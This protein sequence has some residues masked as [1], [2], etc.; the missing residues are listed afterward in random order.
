MSCL[1]L[2]GHRLGGMSN[3]FDW[4][5]MWKSCPGEPAWPC[6][7]VKACRIHESSVWIAITGCRL[8]WHLSLVTAGE[9]LPP[10]HFQLFCRLRLHAGTRFPNAAAASHR[11]RGEHYCTFSSLFLW[12][13]HWPRAILP[14]VEKLNVPCAT[15]VRVVSFL[16]R[17]FGFTIKGLYNTQQDNR[18][19]IG[20]ASYQCQAN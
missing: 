6:L 18:I 11:A 13:A 10:R 8:C 2:R 5:K 15:R 3:W 19:D 14:T 16:Q 4:Y 7:R 17:D 20:R 12:V 1:F 9:A